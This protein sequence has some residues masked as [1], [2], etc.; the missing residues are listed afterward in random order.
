MNN[1][2]DVLVE[3]L[4]ND[5]LNLGYSG[6]S[7]QEVADLLNDPTKDEVDDHIFCTLRRVIERL[8]ES[9]IDPNVTITKLEAA[10]ASNYVVAEGLRAL[11]SY[12]DGG[13]LDF[14]NLAT[15]TIILQLQAANVLT[16]QEAAAILSLGRRK[17]SRAEA[18][19]LTGVNMYHVQS[20][21]AM[22]QE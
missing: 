22:M 1:F 17:A 14:A 19:G 9:G 4:R 11:R 15:R 10:A 18:L 7:D 5:P 12:T 3:E 20:A 6:K 16:D 21:R 2:Y 13:G 8:V